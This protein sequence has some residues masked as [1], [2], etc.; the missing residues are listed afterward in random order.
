MP[1]MTIDDI[2]NGGGKLQP[3]VGVPKRPRPKSKPRPRGAAPVIFAEPITPEPPRRRK[4]VVAEAVEAATP[5]PPKRRR[6]PPPTEIVEA[7]HEAQPT[8][9]MGRF[10]REGFHRPLPLYW[11]HHGPP[12]YVQRHAEELL[13]YRK[14]LETGNQARIDQISDHLMCNLYMYED[15][16]R[17]FFHRP[18][19]TNEQFQQLEKDMLASF[20][21]TGGGVHR[22]IIILDAPDDVSMRWDCAAGEIV[23]DSINGIIFWGLLDTKN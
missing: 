20:D 23:R 11:Q 2:N 14:S 8:A 1:D 17:R 5:E 6:A 22:E 4:P 9:A 21:N 3:I 10:M 15:G 16:L 18:V 13:I 12:D 7:D 19:L